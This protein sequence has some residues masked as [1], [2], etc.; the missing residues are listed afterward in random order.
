MGKKK[1]D[2]KKQSNRFLRTPMWQVVFSK[3]LQQISSHT[4]SSSSVALAL[5]PSRWV[6]VTTSREYGNVTRVN[7]QKEEHFF[8]PWNTCSGSLQSPNKQFDCPEAAMLWGPKLTQ[9]ER[10][11]GESLWVL[12]QRE[13][14]RSVWT[15]VNYS[16]LSPF[17]WKQWQ[18]WEVVF[19]LDWVKQM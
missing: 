1:S 13:T 16:N 5:F 4:C 6:F 15:A 3:W 7:N 10:P 11:R 14:K 8:L 18:W 9:N 17:H 12:E 19:N 2:G